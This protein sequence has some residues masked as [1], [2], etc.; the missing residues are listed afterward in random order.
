[1]EYIIIVNINKIIFLSF[2]L[3]PLLFRRIVSFIGAQWRIVE[4]SNIPDTEHLQHINY[5]DY[6]RNFLIQFVYS[7]KVASRE[8]E[9]G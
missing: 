9:R 3:L 7:W 2:L 6:I 5:I 8:N 1:M 4:I